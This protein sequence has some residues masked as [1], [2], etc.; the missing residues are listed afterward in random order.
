MFKLLLEKLFSTNDRIHVNGD[1]PIGAG[2]AI[3]TN[4]VN[5]LRVILASRVIL[6]VFVN[7][8]DVLRLYG[9]LINYHLYVEIFVFFKTYFSKHQI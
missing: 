1:R 6:I 7:A 3:E 5:R 9:V 2:N 4:A 8:P